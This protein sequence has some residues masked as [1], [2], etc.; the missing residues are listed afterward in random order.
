M[1]GELPSQ[2]EDVT[3]TPISLLDR[4]QHKPAPADWQRLVELYTPLLR[5]WLS[6]YPALRQEKDDLIQEILRCVVAKIAEFRRQRAGSFRRWLQI[7]TVNCVNLHWRKQRGKPSA[8]GGSD[9]DLLLSQLENPDSPLDRSIDAEHDR[10][11]VRR[12]LQ[13]IEPEFRPQTWQAF[14]RHVLDGLP[15]ATVAEELGL[16]VNAILIARS[17][18][19][20]RLREEAQGL[21]DEG[22]FC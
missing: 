3:E 9:G 14:Q 8:V 22:F 2:G 20:K 11:V 5:D 19:L 16:S 7:I 17:R 13:L 12:L 10:F 6:R 21:I 4:L 15:P 1:E 18:I